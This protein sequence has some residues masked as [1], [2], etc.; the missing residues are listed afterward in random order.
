MFIP[1]DIPGR[2]NPALEQPISKSIVY[3]FQNEDALTAH[4]GSLLF[5]VPYSK[6]T[7]WTNFKYAVPGDEQLTIGLELYTS[8]EYIYNIIP[9]TQCNPR[10]WHDTHWPLPSTNSQVNSGVIYIR[11][12]S[13]SNYNLRHHLNLQI[14]GFMDLFPVESN[15]ILLTQNDTYQFVFYM[16]N[17]EGNATIYNVENQNYVHNIIH[18]S[19]GIRLISRY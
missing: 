2:I 10:S 14:L 5:K 6:N 19:Q 16:N 12:Y 18:N 7:F 17:G 9:P 4:D 13:N 8:D 11:V 1:T 3:T 15:Y